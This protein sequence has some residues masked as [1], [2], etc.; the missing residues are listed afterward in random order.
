M[1]NTRACV[2]DPLPGCP[3]GVPPLLPVPL[4]PA[5]LPAAILAPLVW[6]PL[7]VCLGPPV[8][9]VGATILVPASDPFVVTNCGHSF[10]KW[11]FCP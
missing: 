10:I 2:R 11:P 9:G 6:N 8:L 5:P 7:A 4:S 1:A 3:I